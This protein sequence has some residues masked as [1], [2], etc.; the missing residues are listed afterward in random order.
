MAI[1]LTDRTCD[2]GLDQAR[3]FL[4][5]GLPSAIA[6]TPDKVGLPTMTGSAPRRRRRCR[7]GHPPRRW[8]QQRRCVRRGAWRKRA[9]RSLLAM[10]GRLAR[11]LPSSPLSLGTALSSPARS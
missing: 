3:R 5:R 7:A 9:P 6:S 1:S 8:R 4:G 11:R 10:S 2:C